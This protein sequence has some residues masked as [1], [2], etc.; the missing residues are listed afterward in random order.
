MMTKRT[1]AL[2]ISISLILMAAVAMYVF[3]AIMPNFSSDLPVEQLSQNISTQMELYRTAV[4]G[5]VLV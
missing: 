5:I 2:I 3:G 4:L 1:Y